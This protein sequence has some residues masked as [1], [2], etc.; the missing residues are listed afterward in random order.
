MEEFQG[1]QLLNTQQI[2]VVT[3]SLFSKNN[4]SIIN[5]LLNDVIW[6]T[7]HGGAVIIIW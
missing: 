3:H 4:Y 5:N 1:H 6:C 7:E 2:H